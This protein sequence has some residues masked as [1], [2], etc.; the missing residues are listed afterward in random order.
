[1]L[2]VAMIPS[3][4]QTWQL[5]LVGTL[6]GVAGTILLV[7]ACGVSISHGS[8]DDISFGRPSPVGSNESLDYGMGVLDSFGVLA[9]A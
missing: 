6:T 9:F 5:S 1:M 4:S 7:I 2:V 3:L 8:R